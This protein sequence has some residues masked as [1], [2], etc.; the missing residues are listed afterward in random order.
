MWP[1]HGPVQHMNLCKVIMAQTKVM[2]STWSTACGRGAGRVRFQGAK[3]RPAEGKELNGLVSNS[4]K[5]VLKSNKRLKSK[6]SSDSGSEDEQDKFN[7]KTLNNGEE[8]QTAR[9]PRSN[10][11]EVPE[12]GTEAEK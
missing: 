2:K 6:A 10:D 12:T 3:K 1:L 11:T 4:V 8:W 5:E 9:T 7:F